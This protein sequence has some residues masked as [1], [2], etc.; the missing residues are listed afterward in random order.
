MEKDPKRRYSSALALA[1]DIEHWLK[2]EPIQA[3][4]TGIFTRARKW[5]RRNRAITAL[6]GS[7][8]TLAAAMSWSVSKSEL[9]SHPLTKSIAVL[10]FENLSRA[11]DNAF[12]ADGLQDEILTDLARIADLKVISRTFC[13]AIQ[14]RCRA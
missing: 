3:H 13:D 10:P 9:I 14:E 5:V 7:L 2:H 8:V 11:P 6:I 12:L 1:E 4:R